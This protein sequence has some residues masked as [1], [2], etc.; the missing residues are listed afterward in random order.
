M[1]DIDRNA[2]NPTYKQLVPKNKKQPVI[3]IG[4][5]KNL[6]TV[7]V[8]E[9]QTENNFDVLKNLIKKTKKGL[10]ILANDVDYSTMIGIANLDDAIV[11]YHQ[12][13]FECEAIE[14]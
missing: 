12:H 1:Y 13:M 7:V 6:M 4:K 3:E 10:I 5:P 2:I 14:E 11:Y 8:G 9:Y